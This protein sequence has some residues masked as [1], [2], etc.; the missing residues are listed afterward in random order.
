MIADESDH[1]LCRRLSSVIAKYAEEFCN[2]SLACLNLRFSRS[3]AFIFSATSLG[4]PA[5][6][7]L[8]TSAY[9]TRSFSVCAEQPIL[10]AI[11]LTAAQRE[12]C[13]AS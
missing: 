3:G 10:A 4:S 7:P 1:G 2:I 5:R 11:G 8:S 9:F 13:S 6:L 12:L